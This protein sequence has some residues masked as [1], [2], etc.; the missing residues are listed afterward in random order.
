[1]NDC[2]AASREVIHLRTHG[3]D[4][5]ITVE[6]GQ[7]A[8]L[9]DTVRAKA[10]QAQRVLLVVDDSVT[11]T[12]AVIAR[13]ALE[14]VGLE[15]AT[16]AL[17]A[18]EANKSLATVE[19]IY[20]AMLEARLERSS[21]VV[22]IGGGVIC[23]IAGFAAATFHRGVPIVMAPTTLLAMVDA[24][25]GGKNGVNLAGRDGALK[26]M[27]GTIWQPSAIVID[28]TAL[29]TLPE[30]HVRCGL[31][32]CIKIAVLR[33]PSMLDAI[34]SMPSAVKNKDWAS[35]SALIA[36]SAAIKAGIVE[37]DE[38]EDAP[39]GRALL[40]LGHTF[41]HAFELLPALELMHGEAVA[42][43]LCAAAACARMTGRIDAAHE[44]RWHEVIATVGLPT[45]LPACVR[46][47]TLLEL[48]Q[49]DK[50]VLQGRLRLVLPCASGSAELVDDV[51]ERV[52]VDA[53]E[54][55]GATA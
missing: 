3:A 4:C 29:A 32:E 16:I 54:G 44:Q 6:P 41:A 50:K 48:M 52:V 49:R 34:R 13:Q 55:I 45:R 47:G 24:A 1:M 38:R 25:I 15:V 14:R 2:S 12:H 9:G 8:S 35:A 20:S 5:E 39:A 7:L 33:D 40:N 28:P 23:D 51:P 10:P 30:R 18:T 31:A 21:P 43:G 42:I 46:V 26:N 53:L 19:K 17:R 27:V 11:K 22:A 37:A 36:R